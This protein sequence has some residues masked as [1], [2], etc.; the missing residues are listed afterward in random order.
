[1]SKKNI[2]SIIVATILIL[3][4]FIILFSFYHYYGGTLDWYLLSAIKFSVLIASLIV[5][6]IIGYKMGTSMS[7]KGRIISSG[8]LLLLSPFIV[9]GWF[10]FVII[11]YGTLTGVVHYII[12]HT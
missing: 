12:T 9:V 4:P 8:I 6:S 2:I 10:T 1:M 3:S 5:C 11:W 7:T